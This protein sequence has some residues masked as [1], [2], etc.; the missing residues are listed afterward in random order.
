MMSIRNLSLSL[1]LFSILAACSEQTSNP[2]AEAPTDAAS[3]LLLT[4]D[5]GAAVSVVKAKA[6]GAKDKITVEGRI[7]DITTGFA[8]MKLMDLELDY[9]GEVNKEDTCPTP[10]DYCCDAK[11]ERLAHSLLVEARGADGKV[12][13]T[14]SIPGMRLCDKVKVTGKLIIDEHGNHI[15]VASGMFQV[16]RPTMP[17][18]VKW[19]E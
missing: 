19:P 1:S 3:Q 15:L 8:V 14:P 2:K 17:D 13:A 6:D 16:E 18:Y 9:C 12:L 7:Y 11:E 10:W 4:T 5:P